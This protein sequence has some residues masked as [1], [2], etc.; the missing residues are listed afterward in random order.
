M[1]LYL[2]T[3]ILVSFSS[4]NAFYDIYSHAATN[5]LKD[6]Y[7]D[8]IAGPHRS[9]GNTRSREEH[10][11][12]RRVIAS[13]FSPKGVAEY[14]PCILRATQSFINCLDKITQQKGTGSFNITP[15]IHMYTFDTIGDIL[16]G[17]TFHFLENGSD[18]CTAETP[19][20]KQYVAKAIP[21]FLDGVRYSTNLGYFGTGLAKFLKKNILWSSH[22]AKMGTNFSNMSIYRIRRRQEVPP[23][24]VPNDIWSHVM[25][26]NSKPDGYKMPFGELVAE[27]NSLVNA[28]NDTIGSALTSL[29]FHLAANPDVQRK[30]QD[31]ID[32]LI[33]AGTEVCDHET[34]KDAPYLRACIDESLRE[35][36]PVGIGLPRRTPPEGATIDGHF[37]P[38]NTAVSVPTWTVH[39]DQEIFPEPFRYKPDRWFDEKELPNLRKF[40]LPFST[41]G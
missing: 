34:V 20:G 38:G 41:G 30:L 12:K 10:T 13:S 39:H 26:A 8:A 18:E 6:E 7:Y 5:I 24:E 27:A 40:C 31:E 3:C 21:S 22:G 29:V 16:F 32:A 15:Y 25:A 28:G 9:S 37:I 35:R 1:I 2:L 14:E 11:R 23:E 17:N 33:P 36:P 19:E 4:P